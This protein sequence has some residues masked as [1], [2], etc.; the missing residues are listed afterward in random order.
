MGRII[1]NN[2]VYKRVAMKKILLVAFLCIA[3]LVSAGGTLDANFGNGF[4]YVSLP[5]GFYARGL[6]IQDDGKIVIAGSDLL[7]TFEVV[8]YNG[9]GTLDSTF[10]GTG[11]GEIGGAGVP[12]SVLALPDSSL[13]LVGQ[14]QFSNYFKLAK[15]TT[16]GVL[17]VTFG[18]GG[19]VVGP[20]GFAV[21]SA[22]QADGKIIA[23]G[24]DNTGNCLVVRY[25][26]TGAV[27]TTFASGPLGFFESVKV[28]Y[29]GK[30]LAAGT[31]NA[32]NMQLVRYN[33][34]G[35]LDNTFG[36]SGVV[37][38]PAGVA[39]GLVI[40]PNGYY[41]ICGY[42]T[43]PNMLLVRYDNSGAPDNTFGTFGLVT[44]PSNFLANGV[45]LQAN[46]SLVVVG[47]GSSGIKLTRYDS[48]GSLDLSFG[49]SGI[50]TDSLGNMFNI[51]L[52]PNGY[53]V[54]VGNDVPSNNY[55]VARYTNSSAL[56]ATTIT[57]ST[58]QPMGTISLGGAAQNPSQVFIYLDGQL[59]GSTDTDSGGNDTWTYS[60][61]IS[62][63]GLYSL[64][65]VSVYKDG[66]NLS[67]TGDIIRVY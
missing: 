55:Q 11:I 27:D 24:N 38:G 58:M 2:V 1:L 35:T 6:V 59:L 7:N 17:D 9:D 51:G 41:V 47:N 52:Q 67:S 19:V 29:D 3:R 56:T 8:R 65:A 48:S 57:S 46:G 42:D 37:T 21:D 60:T 40:Q 53:I 49:I 33:S 36:I 16:E 23:A 63:V 39:T 18:T 66:N 54:T 5:V 22:L 62:F 15:Y 30:V 12:F 43:N 4:G 10:N 64:R 26:T 50:V 20:Q 61:S 28:Q 25:D 31:D 34:N 14:D 45:A 32:G 13:I 44:G